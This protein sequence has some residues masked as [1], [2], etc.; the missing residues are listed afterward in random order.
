MLRETQYFGSHG[1]GAISSG[2]L[3]SGIVEA[4]GDR[5]RG[6]SDG[7]GLGARFIFTLPL[8]EGAP[9]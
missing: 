1:G 8:A 3:S 5:I 9:S 2:R 4:H 7:P 6:E